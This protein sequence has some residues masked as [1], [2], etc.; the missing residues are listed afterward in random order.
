MLSFATDFPVQES[1]TTQE[2]LL[3]AKKWI[4]SSPHTSI[5]DEDLPTHDESAEWSFK[6][7]NE[8]VISMQAKN[9]KYKM[10]AVKYKRVDDG[11]EWTTNIIFSRSARDTWVAARVFCES[12]HPATRLPIAKKPVLVRTL[13]QEL[14]G[15]QDGGFHVGES[16]HVLN[17]GDIDSAKSIIL[18]NSSCRLPIIY[19]SSTFRGKYVLDVNRLARDMSGVAHVVAEPNRQFSIRLKMEV[20]SENVYG[21]GIGL[22]WPDGGGRRSFF[23]GRGHDSPGDLAAAIF[24]EVRAALTNRRP[25]ERC[26]WGTIQEM[27]SQQAFE[28]LKSIGSVEVE[29]YIEA[30]DKELSS[31]DEKLTDAEREINRLKAELRIYESRSTPNNGVTIRLDSE[32]DLYPN[33]IFGIILDAVKDYSSRVTHDSRRSHVI[34]SVIESNIA[35]NEGEEIKRALKELLRGYTSMDAKI[36]RQ[37]EELG[38]SIA[39]DGKHLK[40]MFQDDARYT[41]ILP[42]SGS[43]HR[44]G[45]N[46]ANDIG[47]LMF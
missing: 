21:G 5:N 41:Y 28:A 35:P 26:T 17:N 36:R 2:F 38:F 22:Y 19:V 42:K 9:D 13:L 37:I 1:R 27:A 46:A 40:L 4:V 44:G 25:L 20:N 8:H 31:K 6:V 33:E 3:A 15:G 7:G 10:A 32:Q 34:A 43:D 18:G 12:N 14:G 29:K 23:I 45:L 11:L 30:F 39:E 16:P 24:D 47:R